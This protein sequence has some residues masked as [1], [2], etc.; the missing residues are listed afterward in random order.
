MYARGAD[1][2]ELW[3][4]LIE[5]A[6]AKLHKCYGALNGGSVSTG[7][8]DMTGG[9]AEQLRFDDMKQEVQNG[10]LWKIILRNIKEGFLMGCGFSASGGSIEGD[11]GN[12]I[13]MNH[14]YGLLD[15]QEKKGQRLLRIRNPW[16][17]SEWTGAW[18]DNSKE[19]TKEMLQAFGHTFADDGTFWISYDDFVV[20]F[21]KLYVCRIYDDNVGER[22]NKYTY[23]GEWKG[24]TA[25]G[26]PG[27]TQ[28][29]TDNT[30]LGITLSVP[31]SEVFIELQQ[32]DDRLNGTPPDYPIPIAFSLMR[33][34]HNKQKVMSSTKDGQVNKIMLSAS[35]EI[36]G[37]FEL[38]N[39]YEYVIIPVTHQAKQESPYILNI[40]CEDELD[41]FEISNDVNSTLS[42]CVVIKGKWSKEEC[43]AGGCMNYASWCDNPQFLI[44]PNRNGNYS[45]E[46]TLSPKAVTSGFYLLK[47]SGQR[48][49]RLTPMDHENDMEIKPV[50]VKNASVVKSTDIPLFSTTSKNPY[51]LIP[52]TF[53]PK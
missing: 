28:R 12:G 33:V 37:E 6:Y 47:R 52:C 22:W 2:K 38:T 41:F 27:I 42:D 20:A 31:R 39:D 46:M 4:S 11:M 10:K 44:E 40:F 14:A 24:K 51:T 53:K 9:C 16:G 1:P 17:E 30:Q 45:I 34:K 5:K 3:V 19:W 26:C 8:V 15:A 36:S 35:R 29:W 50:F 43:T 7:L 48:T 49:R 21:N 25:G 18:A 32:P 23:K 13:L